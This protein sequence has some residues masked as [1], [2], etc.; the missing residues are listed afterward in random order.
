V[1]QGHTITV[2]LPP[3]VE[4]AMSG[5]PPASSAFTGRDTHLRSLL[6]ALAP[7]GD[8]GPVLVSA[9][10]GLAGIGKTE[11]VVQAATRAAK[12][13]GWFPGG[14]LFVDMF[15]YDQQRQLSAGAALIGLLHA[16]GL[17]GEH[18]PAAEAD[19][20]RLF[21]SVLAAYAGQAR[22]ILLVIDNAATADQV[23][24]LLP[25]D[26]ATA[27]LITS[28]HTLDDRAGAR[29]HDLTVLD[30]VA[31]VQLL[32]EV[33]RQ[34]RGP[35]DIRIANEAIAA[36][37]IADLCA[38]LPLALRIAAALLADHPTRPVASLAQALTAEHTRLD[39]LT[40]EDR[41]VRAAFDLSY[42]R[43]DQ[44]QALLFRLLP[45]N[46]GP[47]IGTETAAHLAELDPVDTE[48]LLED[49]ARA[50]LIDPGQ[51]WGRWRLHDLVRLYADE[52][53]LTDP[54]LR[55]RSLTRLLQH[56]RA[57]TEAAA[58]HL[59]SPP[60]DIS[61]QFRD[62][63]AALAWLDD[64]RP[65]LLAACTTAAASGAPDI[66]IDLA[67]DLAGFLKSRR[68]FDDWIIVTAVALDALVDT[69]DW[70]NTGA[71][72]NNLGVALA[73]VRRF[74]EA[75]TVRTHAATIFRE[76]GDR[77]DEGRQ[78]NNLGSALVEVQRFDEAIIAHQ[79][80][81]AIFRQ[82][83]DRQDEGNA[84][85]DLGVALQRV[86][87]F[88]EA[89]TAH[90][91][92]AAIYA[93]TGYRYGEGCALGNLGLALAEMRRFDEAITVHEQA[94]A[95]YVET[96]DR[97]SEGEKLGNL[98]RALAGARRFDEAITAYQRAATIVCQTGDRQG[99]AAARENLGLAL[100]AERRFDEAIAADQQAATLFRET[101][102]RHGEAE[103]LNNLGVAL[104]E[105]RRLDEA[106][107][108]HE[109]AAAIHIETGDRHSEAR[110][111]HNLGLTLQLVERFDEAITVYNQAA[112]IYFETGDRHSE[113][114][115]LQNLGVVLRGVRR[116]D[117][118]R[119]VWNTAI[120]AFTVSG[121]EH[122]AALIRQR[123]DDLPPPD[124]Q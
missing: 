26:G 113:G 55:E 22:R 109:Q 29:L 101:G 116:F 105:A 84:L 38:G 43:L 110:A 87:R 18:I 85:N 118:A 67:F 39:R 79:Q 16:L 5:L 91:Q 31:S 24:P 25:G 51:T 97:H 61:S 108:A 72:L 92:A 106:I 111:L 34:A 32:A 99:E 21:R 44:R 121:D 1:I 23:I 11:L 9:V 82:T 96:G 104:A 122:A 12:E 27:T 49:L 70:D 95:I 124:T 30:R 89:I 58:A 56:Y 102:D 80:A 19:R 69:G 112:T 20:S 65:N 90:Q 52:H 2:M 46:P 3:T 98:G 57:T 14:V 63:A 15:G 114:G 54:D 36:A 107:T 45:V 28:R 17:P 40:R 78:L 88:D 10:A 13:P 68:F 59:L 6:Q 71:A 76:I 94:A 64:E 119:T 81:A 62:Q 115:A 50:H 60:T 33:L 4:P 93:Q 77:S 42:Q 41:A 37:Q 48:R 123:R 53:A 7:D 66:G 47:D 8:G 83:G 117:E 100:A 75:I 73:N 35:S 74:D 86:R 120:D 103:A